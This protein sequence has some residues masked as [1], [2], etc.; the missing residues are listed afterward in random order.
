[1]QKQVLLYGKDPLILEIR[2]FLLKFSGFSVSRVSDLQTLAT[3]AETSQVDL[4]ILCHTLSAAE[5]HT[6]TAL[7]HGL[8]PAAKILTL[9]ASHSLSV[10]GAVELIHISDGPQ[11]LVDRSRQHTA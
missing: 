4:L 11:A 3:L 6:A 7:S 10:D 8:W 5:R 2:G 9:S 1:M